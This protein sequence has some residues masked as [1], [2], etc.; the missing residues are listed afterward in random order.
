MLVSTPGLVLHT[1]PYG[2][3]SVV[4]KVF[5]RQLGL[6]SY[7]VKGVRSRS[8][9]VKQNLLQP[10]SCLD[11]VV[12]DNPHN[13]MNHVKEL[14]PRG[15]QPESGA[16]DNALR[17][18]MTELL[19]KS[20]REGEPLCDLWDYVA[21]GKW[22]EVSGQWPVVCRQDI[23]I[24]S[25]L[26]VARHLG[27]EPLDNCSPHEP[28]FSI[29]EGRFVATPDETTLSAPHSALL[30]HYLTPDAEPPAT[31]TSNDRRAL[32]DALIAYLQLHLGTFTHFHSHDILHS[33]LR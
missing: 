30:H 29:G 28:W 31:A 26:A 7:I 24:C 6:R 3:T 15:P 27:L 22:T 2:E 13:T 23:P 12:Y 20:L 18:F 33:I 11:M 14:S 32:L 16:V 17:F 21:E 8:G 1:T 19:Y 25:L 4:V 10:L 9:H 5:T